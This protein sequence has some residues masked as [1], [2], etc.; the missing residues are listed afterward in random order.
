MYAVLVF[1]YIKG[2]VMNTVKK[3]TPELST[4][5]GSY[6]GCLTL[7]LKVIILNV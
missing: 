4:D 1:K 5:F 3:V 2:E 6:I 7:I